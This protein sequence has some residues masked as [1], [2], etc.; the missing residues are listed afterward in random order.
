MRTWHWLTTIVVAGLLAAGGVYWAQAPAPPVTPGV[1]TAT[2]APGV[3]YRH[4]TRAEPRPLHVHVLKVDLTKA[5]FDLAVN[6]APDPDGDGPAEARL[7]D[8]LRAAKAAGLFAAV[9]CNAFAGLP[10]A[11]GK[12][13]SNWHENMPV[14]IGGLAATAGRLRSADQKGYI[15]VWSD[16]QGR[17]HLGPPGA[18]DPVREGCAGF[19]WAL[20]AGKAVGDDGAKHPRTAAGLDADGKLFVLMVVD[21][22][23]PGYSEG[24]T[25]NELAALMREQGCADAVNLDGGGSSVLL[26]ANEQGE[27]AVRNRPSTIVAGV[28][29]LR[30]V[31]TLLGLRARK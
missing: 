13:S 10:D 9:N 22:R 21:G 7:E 6:V 28:S 18:D 2:P 29:L 3:E 11:S 31:P 12:S 27:L 4:E 8:P 19:G 30:P 1:Q 23:Q 26:L 15:A 14:D 16:A 5:A 20:R 24:V 25:T 17:P